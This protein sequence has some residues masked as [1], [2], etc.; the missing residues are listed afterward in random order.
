M[1]EEQK[2]NISSNDNCYPQYNNTM[3]NTDNILNNN[4][5]ILNNNDNNGS[6]SLNHLPPS[7]YKSNENNT[8]VTTSST[9][10]NVNKLEFKNAGLKILLKLLKGNKMGRLFLFIFFYFFILKIIDYIMIFFNFN[11][12]FVYTYFI[13]FSMLFLFFVLLP[14]KK[15]RI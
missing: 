10:D 15:S 5:N 6:S 2:S 3:P 12:E 13:W 8:S 7:N 1:A 11:R 14:I 4:D 9:R